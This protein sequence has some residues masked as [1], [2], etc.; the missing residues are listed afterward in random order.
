MQNDEQNNTANFPPPNVNE[1]YPT[2]SIAVHPS[3]DNPPWNWITAFLVWLASLL[4][5]LIVPAIAVVLYAVSKGVNF[6]NGE[7]L[8]DFLLN[9][10]VAILIQ[11]GLVIPVHALTLALSWAVVTNLRKFSFRE[12]L[13]WKLG[14][15]TIWHIIGIVATFFLLG[16]ALNY[17]F[18]EHENEITR[19]LKSSRTA[20]YLIAFM[21]SF[22]APIVEEVIYRGLLY[23]AF[24]KRFGILAG[25]LAATIPFALVHYP[26]YWGDWS[27]LII[28]TLLSL[29]LTLIRVKTSNLL[30]CI[31]LHTVFNG[32]QALYM[33]AE[34][35]LREQSDSA[36]QQAA[37]FFHL[38]K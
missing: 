12:M 20:V 21:A 24:Q 6:Q 35:I 8:K 22:T 18:G 32:I 36:P 27:A 14:S 7:A 33:I 5:L 2:F 13:G 3:P 15:F 29:T 23:S 9:D 28:V 38:L 10:S 31:V 37:F 16:V 19:I 26:Q 17:I 11:I 30:P 1:P 34:P 25:V 4:L